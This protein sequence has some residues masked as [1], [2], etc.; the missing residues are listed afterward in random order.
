MGQK[1]YPE[2]VDIEC[3]YFKVRH[4][5]LKT[6]FLNDTPMMIH[7]RLYPHNFHICKSFDGGESTPVIADTLGGKIECP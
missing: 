6:V 4:C 2:S 1:F 3:A 5:H 7:C